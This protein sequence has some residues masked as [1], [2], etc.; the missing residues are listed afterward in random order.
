MKQLSKQ[1]EFSINQF[2]IG[3]ACVVILFGITTV[4]LSAPLLDAMDKW[5]DN[6][7]HQIYTTVALFSVVVISWIVWRVKR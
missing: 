2:L 6:L 4:C 5:M 1:K 7:K 3:S